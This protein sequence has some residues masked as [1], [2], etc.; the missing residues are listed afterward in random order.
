M[1]TGDLTKESTDA[2]VCPANSLGQMLGGVAG[3]IRQEGGD[4]IEK[5]A[6]DRA[7]IQV[8]KAV[9]TRGGKLKARHVIHAP[10]MRIPGE[11]TTTNT[12]SMAVGAALAS[13]DLYN[14]KSVAFPG[15]GTGVGRVPYDEA[16]RIILEEIR[17]HIEKERTCLEC[18][19][20][21][22]NSE[23]FFRELVMVAKKIFT[24]P[25]RSG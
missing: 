11:K 5:E 2:I 13:A 1:K 18:V 14:L 15:M 24:K 3:A 23:E 9:V 6:T 7:P 22:A 10:T 19:K 8:G 4:V 12:V 21:V 17:S 25:K 20:V 16:A